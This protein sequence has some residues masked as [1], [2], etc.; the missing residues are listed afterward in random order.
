MN[1]R[2]ERRALRAKLPPSILG[3][4]LVLGGT[5]VWQA[6]NFVFNAVG[7]RASAQPAMECSRRAWHCSVSPALFSLPYSPPP[8]ARSPR[9]RRVSLASI[10]PILRFYG[11]RVVCAAL[12]LA[13]IAAATSSWI[14][15]LFHLGS[16]WLVVIV[17]ASIPGYVVSHLL[18]GVLQASS[19]LAACPT[20]RGRGMSEG[21]RRGCGYGTAVA[22]PDVRRR[23]DHRELC[24][25]AGEY[26]LI[27]L[28]ILERAHPAGC[29]GE[30]VASGP[31]PRGAPTRI[32]GRG[33]S[34]V[35][36]YSVTALVTYSL[37]ALLLSSDTPIAKRCLSGP[38]AACMPVT[39]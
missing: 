8:A 38:P 11:F 31:G 26:L 28:P 20:E 39:R 17:G 7:A 32:L 24:R 30:S 35:A 6:S 36:T 10:R 25:G 3:A 2:K 15:G 22:F 34:G 13:G 33:G 29:R 1:V 16:P 12:A 14:S 37:L 19:V 27:T 23:D 18:G 4:A 5:L 9:W 21:D